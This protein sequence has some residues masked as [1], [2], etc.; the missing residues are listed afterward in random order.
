MPLDRA[1]QHVQLALA[2]SIKQVWSGQEGLEGRERLE[3]HNGAE[4]LRL[5]NQKRKVVVAGA[6]TG[7]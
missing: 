3:R 4:V 1:N 6:R 7:C 2:S 5:S